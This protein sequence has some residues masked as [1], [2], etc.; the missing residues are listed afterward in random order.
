MNERKLL[1]EWESYRQN[2]LPKPVSAVQ[3]TETRRAFYAGAQALLM[4]IVSHVTIGEE[5][6]EED[7]LLMLELTQELTQFFADVK[8]GKA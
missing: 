8:Q 2:V 1:K 4:L 7:E 5:I 6:T 3:V